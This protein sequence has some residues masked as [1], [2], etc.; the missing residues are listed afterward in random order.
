[1][2]SLR[3]LNLIPM[4]KIASTFPLLPRIL[5]YVTPKVPLASRYEVGAVCLSRPQLQR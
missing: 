4:P 5:P 1:M 3:T 2:K